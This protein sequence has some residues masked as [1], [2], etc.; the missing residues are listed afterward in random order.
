MIS[1]VIPGN[2]LL[3]L[4]NTALR[5]QISFP[6]KPLHAVNDY[7]LRE[8]LLVDP[9]PRAYLRQQA[10]TQFPHLA[11]EKDGIN[12]R[13][14]RSFDKSLGLGSPV[15]TGD[16]LLA[17]EGEPE[18]GIND[19]VVSP[20]QRRR[21]PAEVRGATDHCRMKAIQ[22]VALLVLGRQ[23]SKKGGVEIL[24]HF[25]DPKDLRGGRIRRRRGEANV[26]LGH[27]VGS[28][29]R[30]VMLVH[31]AEM[32]DVGLTKRDGHLLVM[33]GAANV[34]KVIAS[35]A[36]ARNTSE[37]LGHANLHLIRYRGE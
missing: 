30:G 17:E 7:D 16:R 23:G 35:R 15:G 3:L 14:P 4:P 33:P 20:L 27:A 26:H 32:V 5:V 12:L 9:T 13:P 25:R 28:Q 31:P 29:W 36:P 18:A 19:R 10:A 2:M 1:S 24:K 8:H 6:R 22:V 21:G 34:A 11:I 37:V